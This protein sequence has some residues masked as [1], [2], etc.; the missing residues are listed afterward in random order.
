MKMLYPSDLTDSQWQVIES[1]FS[2]QRKTKTDLRAVCDALMYVVKTGCQWRM[3][4]RQY[5]R[6]QVVYYYFQMWQ[7]KGWIQKLQHFLTLKARKDQNRNPHPSAAIIDAQSVKSTLVSSKHYTGYDGGKKI[8]G[9]K[10][11]LL[12]DTSGHLLLS[13]VQPA[14]MADRKAGS[15]I[16]EQLKTRWPSVQKLFADGGYSLVGKAAEPLQFLNGYPLEV[17]TL[18]DLARFKVLPKRWVVERSFSWLETNRRNAKSFERLPR[19]AEAI[20]EISFIKL[21]LNRINI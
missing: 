1:V 16:T 12:V 15:L 2:G 9:I 18:K 20:I 19:N 14:S 10:R 17:V 7:S 5:P 21:I 13:K 3:L 11:T 8:K 6:W 4:P